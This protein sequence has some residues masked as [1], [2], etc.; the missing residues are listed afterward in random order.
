MIEY[1]GQHMSWLCYA[2]VGV[3]PHRIFH[4]DFRFLLAAC[5]ESVSC[6]LAFGAQIVCPVYHWGTSIYLGVTIRLRRLYGYVANLIFA[7]L[8]SLIL[9]V[10]QSDR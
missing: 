1:S 3:S 6:L 2:L 9:I 8:S 4:Y 10:A 7:T 5:I